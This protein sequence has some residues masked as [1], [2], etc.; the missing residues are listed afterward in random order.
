M[1][2]TLEQAK[3]ETKKKKKNTKKRVIIKRIITFAIIALIIAAV[4]FL[5]FKLLK[6]DSSK[7]DILTD[8]VMRGS[9]TSTVSGNGV[10]LAKDSASITLMT[11]GTV[12]EVYVAEGDFVTE[13]TPLYR[14]DSTT[15][16]ENVSKAQKTVSNYRKEL[17]A[18]YDKNNYLT[19]RADYSGKLLDI[20]D[21]KTGDMIT[22]GQKIAVLIDDSKMLL[23]QYYNYAYENDVYV[24]QSA[25]VSIPGSMSQL[26]GTVVDIHKVKRVSSEGSFLFEAVISINNPGTLAADMDASAVLVAKSGETVYPYEPGKLKYNQVTDVLARVSG[27]VRYVNLLNYAQVSANEALVSLTSDSLDIEIA[28]KENIL[29]NAEKDLAAA[30]EDLDKL[31]AVAPISGTVL[32]I[33][34]RPGEEASAGTV[35]ISIANTQTMVINA[36]IDERNISYVSQGMMVDLDQWGTYKMGIVESV[37]LNGQYENGVSVFP[38]V[39]SVDNS[40]GTFMNGSYVTYTFTA[41]Q[42]DD[43]LIVPIQAVKYVETEDG[44]ASVV[45]VK[46]DYAPEDAVTLISDTSDIPSG[47]Y[48]MVVETGIS[49][50]YN[51]EITS[52]LEEGAEV[53]TQILKDSVTMW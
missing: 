3:V 22:E 46:S 20:S 41:S 42:S 36:S 53:F 6:D 32:S 26:S 39:I 33:G 43:C 4:A 25:T 29:Q 7:G 24:G 5:L 18:L 19:V 44:P 2:S 40:D 28:E 51:I 38:A 17:S 52:G 21:I 48:P 15:A 30:Q 12:A 10:A 23:S 27:E 34:I 35:A 11:G 14:I 47:F 9:I 8:Y 1:E 31:H 16:Q 49:D 37:S 45:F 13:G 50:N